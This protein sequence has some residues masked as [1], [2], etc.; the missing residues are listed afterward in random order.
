MMM[1]MEYDLLIR[2]G[3]VVRLIQRS[4]GMHTVIVNGTV[5]YRDGKLTGDIPGQ[6]LKGAAHQPGSSQLK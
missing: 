1:N 4:E 3:R 5:I 2:G 6:V